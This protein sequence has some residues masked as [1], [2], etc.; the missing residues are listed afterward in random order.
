VSR[1]RRST[2]EVIATSPAV[3]RFISLRS[4]G[5][6]AVVPVIFSQNIFPHPAAL[7]CATWPLSSWAAVETRA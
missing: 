2:T 6:S 1:D 4:F 5:R 3:R 7:S